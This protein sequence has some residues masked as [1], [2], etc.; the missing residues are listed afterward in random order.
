M[1][2]AKPIDQYRRVAS[3]GTGMSE[4][5]L[6]VQYA[7]LV[8]RIAFHLSGRLPQTVEIDD[9]IQAG[10]IGLIEAARK[11]DPENGASFETFASIRVRGAMIDQVRPCDWTPRSVHRRARELSEAM[12][13]VGHR[14]GREPKDAE[15]MEELG[16]SVEEYH[17]ALRDVASSKMVSYEEIC[18]T[19][20]EPAG[21][22]TALDTPHEEAD[23]DD[24]RAALA[25]GIGTL[26]EREQQ[27]LSMYYDD[28]LNLR[29]I[30]EVLG[31]TESRVCQIHAKSMLRL[32]AQ[33]LDWADDHPGAASVH[34][35]N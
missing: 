35:R 12:R 26:S 23:E 21:L 20:E 8:K 9:L 3:A 25:A 4:N 16:M 29:E 17:D 32:R 22:P 27:V 31:V 5:E 13:R 15:V 6:V 24:F 30:G 10:T 11:F 19:G 34:R 33:L 1:T 7:P 18:P 14:L 28:E 2:T